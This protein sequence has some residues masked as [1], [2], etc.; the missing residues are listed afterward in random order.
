MIPILYDKSASVF[1]NNGIGYFKDA[2]SYKAYD[3]LNG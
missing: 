3:E 1:T 2:I